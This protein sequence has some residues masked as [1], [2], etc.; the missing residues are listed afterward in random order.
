MI[1]PLQ[2][3]QN[4]KDNYYIEMSRYIGQKYQIGYTCVFI[5]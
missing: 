1:L 2:A 5:P 4:T 3:L